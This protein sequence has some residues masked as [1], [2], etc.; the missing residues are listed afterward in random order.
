MPASVKELTMS[1][2]LSRRS[3]L[4]ALL[5]GL[6]AVPFMGPVVQ[7]GEVTVFAAASLKNALD[8]ATKAYE[9]KT[10]DK[11]VMSYAASSALASRLKEAH[12]QIFS[13]QLISTGWTI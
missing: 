13:F 4:L 6:L 3:L 12:Q 7:A 10:G 5:W 1:A 9:T 2:N 11:V 8:D